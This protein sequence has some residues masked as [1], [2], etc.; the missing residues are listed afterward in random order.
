[1]KKN[2]SFYLIINFQVWEKD[3]EVPECLQ[4]NLHKFRYKINI[5]VAI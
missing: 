3:L 5:P 2:E 1:M 4:T